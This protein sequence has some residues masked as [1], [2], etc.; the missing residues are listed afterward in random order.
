MNIGT[1]NL[2]RSAER[3][4]MYRTEIDVTSL[5]LLITDREFSRKELQKALITPRTKQLSVNNNNIFFLLQYDY[6]TTHNSK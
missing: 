6:V 4:A 1:P 2:D 5:E 3:S